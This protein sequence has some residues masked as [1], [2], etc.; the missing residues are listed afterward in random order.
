MKLSEMVSQGVPLKKLVITSDRRKMI[1]K[2]PQTDSGKSEKRQGP[3]ER[4][5]STEEF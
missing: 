2:K 1:Y 5:F 3:N 4:K